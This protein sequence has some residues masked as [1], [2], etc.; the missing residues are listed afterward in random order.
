MEA[1]S[2]VQINK[3]IRRTTLSS[4]AQLSAP[5]NNSKEATEWI[6]TAE[7]RCDTG[8]CG[9]QAYVKVTG[10]SGS[11]YFCSHHYNKIIDNAVGYDKLE[12]FAYEVVDERGKL[13]ENRLIGD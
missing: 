13:T 12:R 9:A 8:E 3:L 6:L 7:D 5:K 2:T 4:I 10:V 1:A 11:L